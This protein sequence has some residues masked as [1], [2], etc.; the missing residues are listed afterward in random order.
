MPAWNVAH[1][2]TPACFDFGIF[3]FGGTWTSSTVGPGSNH[4]RE[5]GLAGDR[6]FGPKWRSSY[7]QLRSRPTLL[8]QSSR[9]RSWLAV[10]DKRQHRR[11][12]AGASRRSVGE[13]DGRRLQPR[14]VKIWY[15]QRRMLEA[16]TN[17]FRLDCWDGRVHDAH[18]SRAKRR[19]YAH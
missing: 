9:V 12:N 18:Y 8:G 7:A 16:S 4:N 15:I 3:C 10:S 2:K 14:D 17:I 11:A 19:R 6:A 13:F 5:H 1:V